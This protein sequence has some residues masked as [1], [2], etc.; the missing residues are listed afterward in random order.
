MLVLDSTI[1]CIEASESEVL[2]LYRSAAV[3]KTSSAN[4]KTETLEAYICAI[5]KKAQ[6][7]VYLAFVANDRRIYVYTS[8][9]KGASEAEYQEDLQKALD[10]A[11][12]MGFTP[13]P[14]DLS[15][16]PAMREVVV[17]NT[18]I[19]RPPG[20]KA[21]AFLKHGM[22]G[23]PTLPLA[24]P[25]ARRQAAEPAAAVAAPV[26]PPI[27]A[28]S[29]IQT[30][31]PAPPAAT[32]TL[33]AEPDA[34]LVEMRST[35]A[36]LK[37][38][39]ETVAAERD[40]QT[41]QLQQLSAQHREAMQELA[42]AK[43]NCASLTAERDF[44]APY[45]QQVDELLPEKDALKEKL[46]TLDALQ[47]QTA[48]ELA[49][50][51]AD[52][53]RLTAERDAA[54]LAAQE[55]GKASSEMGSLRDEIVELTRKG[56]KA[57][58]QHLKLRAANDAMT[59]NLAQARQD[60]ARITA[61]RDAALQ[62]VEHQ[63]AQIADAGARLDTARK[64][65]ARLGADKEAAFSRIEVLE[66]QKESAE[67]E[68]VALR[69]ELALLAENVKRLEQT[70]ADKILPPPLGE[71]EPA[72]PHRLERVEVTPPLELPGEP[73]PDV[74]APAV[75][76]L[77]LPEYQDFEVPLHQEDE[78]PASSAPAPEPQPT[79]P[80]PTEPQPQPQPQPNEPVPFA[81]KERDLPPIAERIA[82]PAPAASKVPDLPLFSSLP[83]VLSPEDFEQSELPSSPQAVEFTPLGELQADFFSASD[84]DSAP[85]RFHLEPGLQAIEYPSP[86]D[87][88]ELH[89]SI[90]SAYLSP[91]GMGSES[92]QG[93]ICCLK[94]GGNTEVSVAIHGTQSGRTRVYLPEGQP[95]DADAYAR[96][97]RG[98]ISFAE[99]VGLMMEPVLLDSSDKSRKERLKRCPALRMA[100]KK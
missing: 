43:E 16:S 5:R 85:V 57:D 18:K 35:V 13:E 80:Q 7:K 83:P 48:D 64:E 44:L 4:A 67:G 74:P 66:K 70:Q 37:K 62:N 14:V 1:G 54:E 77:D 11:R 78:P 65:L 32:P 69:S 49:R 88:L 63:A 31:A 17:R 45:R 23:A 56:E 58:R 9:G 71:Q 22:A 30:T 19:L 26:A 100:E 12:A 89:H 52:C 2:D 36:A 47:R 90:N 73:A 86:D 93:Y 55:A 99:E 21:N 91:E 6:V 84:D 79:E 50:T 68:L 15:Y 81:S 42:S 61:E 28:F 94:Q 98:A 34:E 60:L 75:D 92:C 8:P 87:V 59:E 33:A 20:S 10:C 82:K 97:L 72:A 38:E 24:K 3:S 25:P 40:G 27:P 46:L 53:A 95:Q 29:P 39:L 76:Q 51:T 41:Q 96:T